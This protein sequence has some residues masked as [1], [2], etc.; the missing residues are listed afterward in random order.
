MN[1]ACGNTALP[2]GTVLREWR[3]ESVLGAGAFGIVYKGRG[4]YFDEI[5][6]IQEF[7]PA[8]TS[9]RDEDDTVIP[10][11][12]DAEEIHAL[13]LK[14]F[15]EE[16]KLLWNL[17]TPMR[18]AG[19]VNVRGVFEMHGTVYMVMDFEEGPA[20]SKRLKSGQ[21]FDEAG[22]IGLMRPI[23]EGLDQAHRVG[24]LHRDITPSSIITDRDGGGVLVGF[25]AGLFDSGNAAGGKVAV[26]SPPYAGIEQYVKT[27]EQGPWT[28]IYALGAV[29]YECVT[30]EMPPEVL[31]RLHGG[32]SVPLASGDWPGF[33]RT[34]L[35]AIDAAMTIKPA[36]RPQSISKWL[37]M[38][39]GSE[40][41]QE[42]EEPESLNEPEELKEPEDQA[43][44]SPVGDT[45]S[46]SEVSLRGAPPPPGYRSGNGGDSPV[47]YDIAQPEPKRA[48]S[49]AEIARK[50]S[51]AP[52]PPKARGAEPGPEQG[53]EADP[54]GKAEAEPAEPDTRPAEE[55]KQVEP[56]PD[57]PPEPQAA[58]PE[59]ARNAKQNAA[60]QLAAKGAAIRS[61]INAQKVKKPGPRLIGAG[62]LAL[63]LL[64]IGG[65]YM[66]DGGS[67]PD[68][69]LVDAANAMDETVSAADL[70]QAGGIV[71]AVGSLL[72]DAREAD[73]P[74]AAVKR[75]QDAS[76]Q[77]TELESGLAGMSSEAAATRKAEMEEVARTAS[78]GFANLLV[79]NAEGR[80]RGL[81]SDMP[82]ADPRSRS[83]AAD[84]S[85][86][87]QRAATSI[88]TSLQRIRSAAS[89]AE[90]AGDTAAAMT[91]A[92]QAMAAST[93]Y[94]SSISRAYRL[95][96]ERAV[97]AGNAEASPAAALSA[98]PA[99][100][101]PA[102]APSASDPA[103]DAQ[104]RQLA[105]IIGAARDTAA[106]VAGMGDRARPGPDANQDAKDRYSIRQAN[107]STAQDYRRYLDTLEDSMRGSRTRA[108]AEQLISQANQ[109]RG[110]LTQLLNSSQATLN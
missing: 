55:A 33:S 54:Q 6:A 37:E 95:R 98:A 72:E 92:R 27:Y 90:S 9:E 31:E 52:P 78:A 25:A 91:A 60:G 79:R 8:S 88:R 68:E 22:L 19:I 59:K 26:H 16:A 105:S 35:A 38:F 81:V 2:V 109:T 57:T 18:Q 67:G 51:M 49:D 70:E 23:A 45:L 10:I 80:I 61:R 15:V 36:E 11:A 85:A 17:S 56:L 41:P 13:G 39:G 99:A 96:E 63:A 110:Y 32:Q 47:S 28:D 24:V 93:A 97:T 69:S 107:V 20:L 101:A 87:R 5:V 58:E 71:S 84:E 50:M 106:K 86:Q 46:I 42:L 73:A 83:S 100:E 53:F 29:L 77:L 1:K 21:R 103:S 104:K 12:S 65:W 89:G 94:R 75:L 43:E 74:A 44:V 64:A 76:T 34:F 14:T 66:S 62:A 48:E 82:W 4:I 7:F 108:E 30:G 40:E 102:P 3:I